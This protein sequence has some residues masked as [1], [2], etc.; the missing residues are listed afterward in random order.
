MT[1]NRFPTAI[2]AAILP[3]CAMAGAQTQDPDAGH[4]PLGFIR[5]LDAVNAGTGKLEVMI[6]GET[7]RPD[8]YQLGNFTGGIDLKPNTYQV[9]F[10]RDGVKEGAI[11]VPVLPNDTTILIPFAEQVPVREG[12][13]ARWRIR[14]LKLK[15]SE[16]E[17]KRTASFV[18]V[19][20][21]AEL[22]V[23]IRQGGK[24]EPIEVKRLGIAR[25]DIRQARGYLP[26]RC[27]GQPLAAISVATTGNFVAVL[28]DDENGTLR[29]R[30]FQ[31]YEY[32]GKK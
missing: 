1:S 13:P 31:D 21:Q 27:N 10:R 22:K 32:S 4:G 25:A 5:L 12:E 26:V 19:S 11:Q 29:S 17:D 16:T 9:M 28:F 20:R 14:I 30:N 6:D 2:L 18:S 3:W 15:P 24:W 7:V 8:G 23:E